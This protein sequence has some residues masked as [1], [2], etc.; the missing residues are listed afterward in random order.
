M[1]YK[2]VADRLRIRVNGAECRVGDV[3][4]GEKA[5]AEQY[6]VSRMTIR[7]AVDMLIEWGLVERRHGSGTYVT[8][9]DV[10]HETKGLSGFT[11]LM[12]EQGRT[13]T[14]QVLEFRTMPAP[15]A[16]ASQ[17]RVK[18]NEPVYYSSRIRSVDGRAL[19]LEESY[20]P[21]RLFRNLSVAHLEGSKFD[22][23]ERECGIAIAGN[24]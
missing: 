13:L 23:I 4:P 18:V 8:K 15:P 16:I 9:K 1:I 5:L 6:G 20:M 21:V 10:Q 14:S 7:K 3:L 12:R 17:L 24:Y 2:S 22:Y 19:L 11:E